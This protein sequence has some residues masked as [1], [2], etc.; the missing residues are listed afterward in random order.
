MTAAADA[1]GRARVPRTGWESRFDEASW[2]VIGLVFLALLVTWQKHVPAMSDTWYHLAIADKALERGAVPLWDDWE[3]AP[4][5]RP[6]LYPPLLH[7]LLSGIG[8]VTGG[9]L[10]A[11]KV[12]TVLILPASLL[13]T[14]F[15]CRRMLGA[16]VAFLAVL[17]S[18]LDVTQLLV[19]EAYIAACLTNLLAPLVLLAVVE[20]RAWLGVVGMALLYYSHLGFPHMVALG[21]LVFGLMERSYLRTVLKVVGIAFLWW[22]PYLAHVLAN[23]EW[24]AAV[25]RG[26]GL[27][28]PLFQ[29]VFSLQVLNPI[30]LVAGLVGARALWRAGGPARAFPCM[31]LGFLPI[32]LTY[33]GRYM[34]HSM[35]FWAAAGAFAI[36][37]L[38]PPEAPRIRLTLLALATILPTPAIGFFGKPTPLPFTAPIA[39]LAE[40]ATPGGLLGDQGEKSERYR[41]DC[42]QLAEWLRANTP[43]DAVIQTNTEWIAD[44]V[45]LFADRRVS[46]GAWW[47]CGTEDS[48]RSNRAWR[49]DQPEMV[50]VAI[51][52]ENDAGSILRKTEPMPGVDEAFEL[53]RFQVGQRHAHE[54]V[55]EGREVPLG[56][57][58]RVPGT[59]G[60]LG[61]EEDLLHWS[62]TEAP[63]KTAALLADFGPEGATCDGIEVRV[64]SDR[65]EPLRLALV[66]AEVEEIGTEITLPRVGEWRV[67]RIPV[68]WMTLGGA[69]RPDALA[70]R[71]PV[72]VR[73][74]YLLWSQEKGEPKREVEV[75]HVRL[76]TEAKASDDAR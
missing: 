32:L 5:G 9:V 4:H 45:A 63:T 37:G 8:A 10:T 24:V 11:G 1:S 64:R 68:A 57:F 44:S 43:R 14:W 47:E 19:M 60:G 2:L 7:V 31:L 17:V 26:G 27:P 71:G 52:P 69:K 46:Y 18:L 3:F 16:S 70:G 48:K 30:I 76:L 21:L 41:A 65:A 38:A 40:M 6:N 75:H 33:G 59:R 13:S 49:D 61:L 62:V 29:K 12:L 66:T 51:R 39:L 72:T 23:A 25:F 73:R 54:W 20:R 58:E 50:F 53:G 34:M 28:V 22:T 56:G 55:D 35:P 36:R 74:L 67:A 42:D 15:V